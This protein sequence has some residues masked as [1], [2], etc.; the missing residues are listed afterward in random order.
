MAE[1]AAFGLAANIA[2]FVALAIYVADR[3]NEF[4]ASTH[5]LPKTFREISHQLPLLVDMCEKLQKTGASGNVTGLSECIKGC[6]DQLGV[7]KS[8]VSKVLPNDHDSKMVRTW[9]AVGSVRIESKVI[10]AQRVLESY[11]TTLTLYFTQSTS[12]AGQTET[13]K[14]AVQRTCYFF[15]ASS[16][17][18]FVGRTE[19]LRCVDEALLPAK[20]VASRPSVA[21][22]LGLGGQGK[23][24]IALEHCRQAQI[25]GHFTSILWVDATSL[26]T[27]EQSFENI[28]AEITGYSRTFPNSRAAVQ[29]VKRT[30]QEWAK[31]WLMIFDNYDHVDR[32]SN[33][34]DYTPKVADGAVLITS[35]SEECESLG[36]P[37]PVS[38]MTEDESIRLLLQQANQSS[39]PANKKFAKTVVDRLGYL[40]LAIDQSA[41][42]IRSKKL[43]LS[44]FIQ[45]YDRRRAEILQHTPALWD[46][47]HSKNEGMGTAP[48]SVY[49][50]WE[51]SFQQVGQRDNLKE[52]D[53]LRHFL[54]LLAFFHNLDIQMP[55][56]AASFEKL[57]TDD[58][59]LRI[60]A[61]D[62]EWDP[63]DYQDVVA[64][65]SL[66]SLLQYRGDDENLN[67][68][69]LHPLVRDWM[70]LRLSDEQRRQYTEEAITM[71][72]TYID[73]SENGT[74]HWSLQTTT[75]A[76]FHIDAC[77]GN[78]TRYLHGKDSPQHGAI[79]D[80]INAFASFY[81][82]NGRYT[83]AEAILVKVIAEKSSMV[84]SQQRIRAQLHLVDVYMQLSRY[85]EASLLLGEIEPHIQSCN[86]STEIHYLSNVAR[87]DFKLGMYDD[88]VQV[89]LKVIEKQQAVLPRNHRQVLGTYASLA[90]VYRNQGK[91]DEAFDI[92]ATTMSGY[93]SLYSYEHPE[94][95]E[96]MVKLAN[97]YRNGGLCE[98]A[99]ELYQRAIPGNQKYLGPDHPTTLMTTVL[100]G[101]NYRNML[102]LDKSEELFTTSLRKMNQSLGPYHDSTLKAVS[103]LAVNYVYKATQAEGEEKTQLLSQAEMYHRLALKGREKSLG[104]SSPYTMRT[105]ERLLDLMWAQERYDEAE[106]LAAEIHQS[107]RC[108]FSARRPSLLTNASERSGRSDSSSTTLVEAAQGEDSKVES[109]FK[110]AVDRED[111]RLCPDHPDLLEAMKSLALVYFRLNKAQQAQGLMTQIVEGCRTRF[112]ATNKITLDATAWLEKICAVTG[113]SVEL[114]LAERDSGSPG[115]GSEKMNPL[116]HFRT[117]LRISGPI[118]QR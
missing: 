98:K 54:T 23:T 96:T 46:Y 83:E 1:A 13:E 105:V 55:M 44:T 9:K 79:R 67:T 97:C 40:P 84:D 69:S 81:N 32:I 68:V 93:T 108:S 86:Q 36:T 74:A 107:Q 112:G 103:N 45:H 99:H 35:R 14:S 100:H 37:I 38:G 29:F 11:K 87:R 95:L 104:Y 4:Q 57:G 3:I 10:E 78:F 41:A 88:A 12:M 118:S 94:L 111:E 5:D 48:M 91:Y 82:S 101:I 39:T 102:D 72:K 76:L 109:I 42:Y 51:L 34:M 30:V 61:R 115:L 117:V 85:D 114:L 22:L 17:A 113:A 77:L 7:L 53:F 15:P 65:L 50:T 106:A 31:P 25:N 52:R 26:L 43:P 62:S 60:F 24:S 90:E 70:Q 18:K 73:T 20:P 110:M 56:F 33:I 58:D 21:V 89:Y 64:N 75:E 19:V 47:Q 6:I 59:F 63:L 27:L 28:S 2:Q 92:F 16:S 116:P 80:A 71:V 8:L 49:T 66:L